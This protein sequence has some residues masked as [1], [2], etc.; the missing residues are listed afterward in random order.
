MSAAHPTAVRAVHQ[1]E[2]TRGVGLGHAETK[3]MLEHS[4]DGKGGFR[5][6]GSIRSPSNLS[7]TKRPKWTKWLELAHK[8]RA[9][10]R[11]WGTRIAVFIP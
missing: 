4:I 3:R 10:R 2:G 8:C 1:F 5:L 11:G 7:R 6:F 9:D